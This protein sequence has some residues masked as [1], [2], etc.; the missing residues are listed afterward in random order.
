MRIPAEP[1]QP[2]APL[3]ECVRYLLSVSALLEQ[4]VRE[5][6]EVHFGK[7]YIRFDGEKKGTSITVPTNGGLYSIK[8]SIVPPNISKKQKQANRDQ[9]SWQKSGKSRANMAAADS[10]L[11][12]KQRKERRSAQKKEKRKRKANSTKIEKKSERNKKEKDC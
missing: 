3:A 7:N 6:K 9:M 11:L 10:D 12:M 8:G 5:G 4:A 2:S 1:S